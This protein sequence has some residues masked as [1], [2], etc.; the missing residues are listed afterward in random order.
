[1]SYD[2]DNGATVWQRV[3]IIMRALAHPLRTLTAIASP[4]GKRTK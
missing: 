3:K 1:M 4:T 2:T